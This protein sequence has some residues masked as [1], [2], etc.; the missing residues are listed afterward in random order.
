[1]GIKKLY[2]ETLSFLGHRCGS[3]T[4]LEQSLEQH[5]ENSSSISV[6]ISVKATS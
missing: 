2:Q 1:M 4:N 6:S 3:W 5:S